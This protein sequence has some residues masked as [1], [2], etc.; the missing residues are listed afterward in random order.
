M[1]AMVEVRQWREG[2]RE[3]SSVMRRSKAMAVSGWPAGGREGEREGG[4]EGGREGEREG[5][6]CVAH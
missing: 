2:G 4:R 6:L 5:G 1:A 3:R